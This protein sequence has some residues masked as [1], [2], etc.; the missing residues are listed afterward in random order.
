MSSQPDGTLQ[1]AQ[2]YHF[3]RDTANNFRGRSIDSSTFHAWTRD[4]MYKSSYAKF[5]SSV[6]LNLFSEF[7]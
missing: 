3:N 1:M 5:H 7:Y 6:I 2:S 4:N